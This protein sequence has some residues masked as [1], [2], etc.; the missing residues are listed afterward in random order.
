M[1]IIGG[2]KTTIVFALLFL[3]LDVLEGKVMVVRCRMRVVG[4]RVCVKRERERE[5][6]ETQVSLMC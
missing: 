4:V 3:L 5:R 6:G 2:T 1:P